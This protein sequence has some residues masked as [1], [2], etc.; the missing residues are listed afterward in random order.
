M[1]SHSA[2]AV[3]PLIATVNRQNYSHLVLMQQNLPGGRVGSGRHLDK[4]TELLWLFLPSTFHLI[5][6]HS[7]QIRKWHISY[8]EPFIHSRRINVQNIVSR[9]IVGST[10]CPVTTRKG[11]LWWKAPGTRINERKS[12]SLNQG[13][14]QRQL[15]IC[16]VAR[17]RTANQ[18]GHF[19]W[20]VPKFPS[21]PPLFHTPKPKKAS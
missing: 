10:L 16:L 14:I 11:R 9:G 3:W 7:S 5:F 18:T 15:P 12:H 2:T 1:L 8:F 6:Y 19:L 13:R 4:H 17:S 21:Y 20:V